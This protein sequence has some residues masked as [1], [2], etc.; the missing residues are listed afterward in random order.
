MVHSSTD[1]L[2]AVGYF[3]NIS[4]SQIWKIYS[5]IKKLLITDR[6]LN[7]VVYDPKN[8]HGST[9]NILTDI[10]FYRE[11]TY[12]I[13][14]ADYSNTYSSSNILLVDNELFPTD[15]S[16]N[17]T[18]FNNTRVY[19]YHDKDITT[20]SSP[21]IFD[22]PFTVKKGLILRQHLMLDS[23]FAQLEDI[24]QKKI[25][26]YVKRISE[27]NNLVTHYPELDINSHIEYI[28]IRID[29]LT[30]SISDVRNLRQQ[31]AENLDNL[32]E[33]SIEDAEET[34]TALYLAVV[35]TRIFD[36]FRY[37]TSGPTFL[38][39]VA[40][41]YLYE[42]DLGFSDNYNPLGRNGRAYDGDDHNDSL[43]RWYSQ[44]VRTKCYALGNVYDEKY[45]DKK[46]YPKGTD[47]NDDT[48]SV[49]KT[50]N[51]P[52][53]LFRTS[54]AFGNYSYIATEDG[55]YKGVFPNEEH[56][57][58]YD[59]VYPTYNVNTIDERK[60]YVEARLQEGVF[61]DADPD[62][63]II[64]YVPHVYK[65]LLNWEVKP[66]V[67]LTF[68]SEDDTTVVLVGSDMLLQKTPEVDFIINETQSIYHYH[69][70]LF[71]T[72]DITIKYHENFYVSIQSQTCDEIISYVNRH[73]DE[74]LSAPFAALPSA[75]NSQNN[76]STII[77]ENSTLAEF[78]S[79]TNFT[80]DYPNRDP[81]QITNTYSS[82][83]YG[84]DLQSSNW[85]DYF[86]NLID[87]YANFSYPHKHGRLHPNKGFHK[88]TDVLESA[89]HLGDRFDKQH[90]AEASYALYNNYWNPS[91]EDLEDPPIIYR[92]GYSI[93]N[94]QEYTIG[95]TANSG[96]RTNNFA[97]S[98]WEYDWDNDQHSY[99]IS[100]VHN[101]TDDIIWHARSPDSPV[102]EPFVWVYKSQNHF[103]KKG[104][105]RRY[106]DGVLRY[107]RIYDFELI[108]N[109]YIYHKGYN[110]GPWVAP[111]K[112][113]Y[114][115]DDP[116]NQVVPYELFKD[117]W[118]PNFNRQIEV[119]LARQNSTTTYYD[120]DGN[121]TS[122]YTAD[123]IDETFAETPIENIVNL[124]REKDELPNT[125]G[126]GFTYDIPDGP[127]RSTFFAEGNSTRDNPVAPW[128]TLNAQ[129]VPLGL[130]EI[131]K[132]H[133]SSNMIRMYFTDRFDVEQEFCK[134]H[135]EVDEPL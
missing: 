132:I 54:A 122:T 61:K 106:D 129:Y 28:Q 111:N 2:P 37:W 116:Y 134:F 35:N 43:S 51:G 124:L 6:K 47:E 4:S 125:V 21:L 8:Q 42:G 67:I 85:S 99:T 33:V 7:S 32:R 64:K 66:K 113:G 115:G 105:D 127:L 119:L 70:R 114:G 5:S 55:S 25:D 104:E 41:E 131:L 10:N 29:H 120:E 9:R 60:A 98:R 108:Q 123:V 31:I 117:P 135:F 81:V 133:F 65:L 50:T 109:I 11:N 71:N 15:G 20:L 14:S 62:N 45:L 118:Q 36:F 89:S 24:F 34:P 91:G 46:L 17:L 74:V 80:K 96:S 38:R 84:G 128:R 72:N 102:S 82:N 94:T 77:G 26:N 101:P 90:Y 59:S 121:I 130:R 86:Q 58:R 1:P 100:T 78:R 23:L 27:S 44:K 3:N 39:T 95:R 110:I 18:I 79:N 49:R 83:Y 56:L 69:D 68:K 126:N 30:V 112:F 13:T 76:S 22:S 88:A 40:H 19:E 53:I 63:G 97:N 57:D 107:Q 87:N 48:L 75:G 93:V 92:R 52:V 73:N 12:H 103:H 16:T